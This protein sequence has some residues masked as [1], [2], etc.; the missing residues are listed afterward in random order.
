[1]AMMIVISAVIVA[2]VLFIFFAFAGASSNST[3]PENI[4]EAVD[5]NAIADAK[6]QSYLPN[7]KINAIK[8]Y[9]EITGRGLKEAKEAVEYA[10]AHPEAGKKSRSSRQVIDTDG[11]GVRDLIADGRIEEAIDIYATFMGIDEYSARDAINE[12]QRE[13]NLDDVAHD[14]GSSDDY[15]YSS[16]DDS[17][18]DSYDD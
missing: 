13:M 3:P 5:W 11:A 1:M 15:F 6:L 16:D 18:F 14:S 17:S 7:K 10:M 12:M 8:R 4:A 2:I 9:R